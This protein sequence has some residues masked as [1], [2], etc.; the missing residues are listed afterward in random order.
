MAD[1]K[2]FCC[3]LGDVTAQSSEEIVGG[4]LRFLSGMRVGSVEHHVTTYIGTMVHGCIRAFV[5]W[6]NGAVAH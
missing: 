2:L 3:G 5:Q 6:C 4:A 1:A